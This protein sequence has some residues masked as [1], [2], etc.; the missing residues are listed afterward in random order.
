MSLIK[1]DFQMQHPNLCVFSARR[2]S[3]KTHLMTYMIYKCAREY[4]EVIIITPTAFNG[5]YK[6]IS[7]NVYGVF[8]E[9]MIKYIIKRQAA[10]LKIGKR[11]KVLL[12]LDDCLSKANFGSKIFE[13]IAT[14]G[15]HYLIS[16]WISTQHYMKLLPVIRLN[17][18]YM[19]IL[20]NQSKQ[21]MKKKYDEMGGYFN[22]ETEFI[23]CVKENLLEYGC[24]VLNN[25]K[26]SC[27]KVKAP[28]TLP[29]FIL[30]KNK[31]STLN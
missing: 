27:H 23:K 1:E 10:N 6:K 7:Q 20:G 13:L 8:D 30:K 24:L 16:C 25:L 3:G 9:N 2:N 21:V 19:L 26:G 12:I 15:R 4:N 31:T 17:A 29:K 14:Q 5:H 22:S 11:N 28:S 18:D